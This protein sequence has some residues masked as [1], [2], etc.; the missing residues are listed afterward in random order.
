MVLVMAALSFHLCVWVQ[1]YANDNIFLQ[2]YS[3]TETHSR[4]CFIVTA[5]FSG[6]PRYKPFVF[7]RDTT[8]SIL[9]CSGKAVTLECSASTSGASHACFLK[10][11]CN[12]KGIFWQ[13]AWR[14][15][16]FPSKGHF[17]QIKTRMQSNALSDPFVSHCNVRV[18]LKLLIEINSIRRSDC[19]DFIL[20]A[21][22]W[23]IG[24][25][26]GCKVFFLCGDKLSACPHM[27]VCMNCSHSSR[28]CRGY[29]NNLK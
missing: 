9:V 29:R 8:C 25:G 15:H 14:L 28:I 4:P 16:F 20:V 21:S 13:S 7:Y 19:L 22:H 12:F 6:K 27:T 24:G 23:A 5:L 26:T 10:V 17:L 1:W 11:R 2:L 3:S 18:W